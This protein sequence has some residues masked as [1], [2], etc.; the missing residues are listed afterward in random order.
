M[1]CQLFAASSCVRHWQTDRCRWTLAC[2]GKC[3]RRRIKLWHG[4]TAWVAVCLIATEGACEKPSTASPSCSCYKSTMQSRTES[5]Y[6]MCCRTRDETRATPLSSCSSLLFRQELFE[7]QLC[8]ELGTDAV[9]R[10]RIRSC[11]GH[12]ARSGMLAFCR[13]DAQLF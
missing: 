11:S 9:G 2:G 4:M 13:L 12:V 5:S 8:W 1:L 3:L 7:A 10:R 6:Q